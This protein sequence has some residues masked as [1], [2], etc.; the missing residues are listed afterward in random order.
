M[1]FFRRTSFRNVQLFFHRNRIAT[2]YCTDRNEIAALSR[3][4]MLTCRRTELH[5]A[6][7]NDRT[8]FSVDKL[9]SVRLG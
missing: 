8:I 4:Q 3:L 6:S 9:D 5:S 1:H 2:Q 7:N